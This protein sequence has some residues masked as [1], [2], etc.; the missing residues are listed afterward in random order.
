MP[1]ERRYELETFQAGG[2]FDLDGEVVDDDGNPVSNVTLVVK[3]EADDS[4]E[5]SVQTDSDGKFLLENVKEGK[6]TVTLQPDE[7]ESADN[8]ESPE[9]TQA[10]EQGGEDSTESADGQDPESES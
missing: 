7:T 1:S 9:E 4:K 3:G 2:E 8:D 10:S 6:Y 5:Y